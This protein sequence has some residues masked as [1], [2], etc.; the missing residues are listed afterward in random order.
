MNRNSLSL[1]S[2]TEVKSLSLDLPAG[3]Q[4]LPA[5]YALSGFK[6]GQKAYPNKKGTPELTGKLPAADKA[7]NELHTA[8]G[9]W[10]S[11]RAERAIVALARSRG[12]RRF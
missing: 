8:L 6:G 12:A 4:L 10:D 3:E 2:V 1:R 9:E 5:F 7:L 11:D